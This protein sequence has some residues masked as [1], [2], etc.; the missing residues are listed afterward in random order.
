[1]LK[2]IIAMLMLAVAAPVVAGQSSPAPHPNTRLGAL[3]ATRPADSYGKLFD[4]ARD[5][6]SPVQVPTPSQPRR[7]C[8]M[9]IVEADPYFDQKMIAPKHDRNLKYT[10]R[11]IDPP[12]CNPNK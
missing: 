9:T 2:P 7:V 5:F 8:G 1:M 6:K 4:V 10:I 12:V 11:A 3:R